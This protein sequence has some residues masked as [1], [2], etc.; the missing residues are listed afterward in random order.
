MPGMKRLRCVC[1]IVIVTSFG[2]RQPPETLGFSIE[3]VRIQ[4]ST[5]HTGMETGSV[6]GMSALWRR[7]VQCRVT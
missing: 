5:V 1:Y 4:A 3:V 2:Q 7:C 6:I